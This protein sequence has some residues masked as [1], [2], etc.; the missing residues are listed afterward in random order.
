MTE[1]RDEI[2]GYIIEVSLKVRRNSRDE[3]F[4]LRLGTIN[5]SR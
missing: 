3:V 4:D 2:I 1:D 5:L